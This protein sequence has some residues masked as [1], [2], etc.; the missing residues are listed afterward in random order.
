[1]L[2]RVKARLFFA[3]ATND[4]SIS[5]EQIAKFERA[6]A[7]W[8]GNSRAASSARRTAGTVPGSPVYN[9]RE[10][11]AAFAKLLELFAATLKDPA[12]ARSATS[13]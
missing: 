7:D 2:P 11:E 13:S 10:A 5:T 12:T 4:H 3:H 8:G 1:M 6:L 9:E